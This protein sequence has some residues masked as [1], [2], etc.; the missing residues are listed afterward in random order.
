VAIKN[1]LLPEYHLVY[2]YYFGAVDDLQVRS[3]ADQLKSELNQFERYSEIIDFSHQVDFTQLSSETL[4]RA[5]YLEKER[6]LC[7]SGKLAIVVA[8]PLTYGLARTYTIFAEDVR[9]E[10]KISYDLEECLTFVGLNNRQHLQT[11]QTIHNTWQG[12]SGVPRSPQLEFNFPS[13]H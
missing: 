5:G 6:P 12:I 7:Q 9:Q 8:S 2:T 3:Y 11:Q 10:I 4:N 13:D 1:I